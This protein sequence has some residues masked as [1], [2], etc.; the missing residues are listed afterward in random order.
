MRVANGEMTM[1]G[2][3]SEQTLHGLYLWRTLFT[4]QTVLRS[5]HNI[6][7]NSR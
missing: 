7:G 4:A 3:K 1:R 6:V 2:L 5:G